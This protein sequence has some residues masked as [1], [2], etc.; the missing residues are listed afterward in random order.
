MDEAVTLLLLFYGLEVVLIESESSSWVVRKVTSL[1]VVGAGL[2]T[3]CW[4]LINELTDCAI[5]FPLLTVDCSFYKLTLVTQSGYRWNKTYCARRLII[6][7][8]RKDDKW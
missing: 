1:T 5:F 8:T 4:G 2:W 3:F 6:K 7:I